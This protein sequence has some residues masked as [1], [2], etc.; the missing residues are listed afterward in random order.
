MTR[1]FVHLHV[2]SEYSLLDGA[3]RIEP[4]V[5]LA[6]EQGSPAIAIT[7][8]GA[9]YG[10]VPFYKAAR[11]AGVKPII[12][13]EVYVAQRT[14]RDRM[15]KVDDDPYHLVLLATGPEGYRNLVKLVSAASLEGF[16]YKPRVD[17]ELLAAH[18]RGLI[19][20]SGCL[21]GEIARHILAGRPGEALNTAAFYRD[22]FGRDSFFVEIQNHHLEDERRVNPEL[23]RLARELDLGLVATNDPHYLH[24]GDARAHDVLLCIQTAAA[25]GD[26]GRMRF[27]NDEFYLKS[28]EEMTALFRDLPEALD[29]TVAIAER[30]SFRFELGQIH[31]PHYEIPTGE[32]PDAYLERLCRDGLVRRYGENPS[33]EAVARLDRELAMIREMGY[34]G[35]FLIVWDFIDFAR[36]RQIPVGPGRGSGAGCLAAYCLN[37]TDIDPI[38]YGLLFDRFL[39]PERIDRP[40]IDTDLCERRRDEVIRYVIDKYGEDRVA[41]IVAF[42]TI[43]ARGAIRDV[44]RALGMAYGEV[45]RIARMVPFQVGITLEKAL[46]HNA[47]LRAA[48]D[49]SPAVQDLLDLARSVEGLPRHPSVHAAGVVIAR[50]PLTDLVPLMRGKDDAVVTQYGM[51]ALQDLGLIKMDFLGLRTLTVIDQTVKIVRRTRGVE[52]EPVRFPRDDRR[53]LRML[54]A[55]DT[56]GVFQL[57]SGGMTDLVRRLRPDRFE[58]LV[59]VLALFRPG[60]LGSGM[61]DDFVERRHGRKFEYIHPALESILKDT[62]GVM[63]Y[64]EQVMRVA[65][66][67]AGFSLGAADL[68]RRAISKKEPEVIAAQRT[69]FIDGARNRGVEPATAEKVF[70]L[71]EHFAGYGFNKSH[72]APYALLAWETAYLKAYYPLE[73][74]A[75]LLTSEMGSAAKVAAYI[76]DCRRLGVEV[77]PPDVN[78][79]LAGFTVVGDKLRFGLAAV[80]NVGLAAIETIIANRGEHGPFRSLQDLCE[81]MESRV[82]NKRVAESLIKAGALDSLG[83]AR[84]RMLAVLDQVLEAAGGSQRQRQS[85]QISFFDLGDSA[86][87]FHKAEVLLPDISEYPIEAILAYEKE[88]LGLYL[89]GHPL[90]QFQAAIRKHATCSISQLAGMDEKAP[91]TIGGTVTGGRPI[92]TKRGEPMMFLNVEDLTASVEVVVFPRVYQKCRRWLENDNV[93]IVRGHVNVTERRAGG[94]GAAGTGSGAGTGSVADE[95]DNGEA[96][97]P[98]EET[99]ED[100]GSSPGQGRAER[101]ALEPKIIADDIFVITPEEAAAAREAASRMPAAREAGGG[102][103][104]G[105]ANV[106]GATGANVAGATAAN[107]AGTTGTSA[108][109]CPRLY[110]NV[111]GIERKPTLLD[112]LRQTLSEHQGATPVFLCFSDRRLVRAHRALW[113]TL[114]AELVE[115]IEAV[116]G[117]GSARVK[118]APAGDMPPTGSRSA[119]EKEYPQT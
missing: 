112:T 8:H 70:Q 18:S 27:P 37:I 73:Y 81:R 39:N 46:A 93:V 96:G 49:G 91:V 53:V 15:P 94:G 48:R 24:R 10:A 25:L 80:K 56:T 2:H 106:A 58:D 74:M 95:D 63:V 105:A 45:D 64:Q 90:G 50:D 98:P 14:R 20:L 32:S 100:E 59:A 1:P 77:L 43:A 7:D 23:V 87:E 117:P 21:G 103:A 41:Q 88:S 5:R 28:P 79:S 118:P 68:L 16:Y 110:I 11:A 102:G 116:A 38:Q 40:D 31:L 97:P 55:G 108:D 89:S 19:A 17:R 78:E 119:G 67:M 109:A 82:L 99:A 30:C 3:A 84:S 101:R 52:L 104:P 75:A 29:N 85:G 47:D 69:A 65:N 60:P 33:P 13:C 6:R 92:A 61:V 111:A 62:Y 66:V 83:A 72:T 36:G 107:V 12:G 26:S 114:S 57:E 44:G 54:A 4:M 51:K 42:S 86:G 35:Y 115:A 22:V 113:V 76:E 9:M 71:I 34:S